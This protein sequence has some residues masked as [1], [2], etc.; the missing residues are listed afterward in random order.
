MKRETAENILDAAK[1]I[2]VILAELGDISWEIDDE[3]ERKKL[4]AAIADCIFVLYHKL[5]REVAL[6]FPD[7]HPDF[8]DGSWQGKR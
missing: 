4:R 8:P 5:T 3:A 6:D 7:L 2:D 1:R